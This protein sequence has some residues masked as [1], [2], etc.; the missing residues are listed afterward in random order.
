MKKSLKR[1]CIQHADVIEIL[2]DIQ[3]Q[4]GRSFKEINWRNMI[5]TVKGLDGDEDIPILKE[6]LI[7]NDTAKS[8]AP[9]LSLEILKVM[10]YRPLQDTVKLSIA[11]RTCTYPEAQNEENS[12][13][14][15][16]SYELKVTRQDFDNN[17]SPK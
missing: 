17:M 12:Y 3:S 8:I 9:R 5:L 7:G 10:E 15:I 14:D 1:L 11:I 16:P 6:V 2:E 4:T 13:I